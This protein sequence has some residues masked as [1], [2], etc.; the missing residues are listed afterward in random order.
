MKRR[1]GARAPCGD[2]SGT[3]RTATGTGHP[4]RVRGAYHAPGGHAR[5]M[6]VDVSAR[7]R[8]VLT[9]HGRGSGTC[10]PSTLRSGDRADPVPRAFHARRL[11][12]TAPKAVRLGCSSPTGRGLD[13]PHAGFRA[14]C[15]VPAGNRHRETGDVDV[16]LCRLLPVWCSVALVVDRRQTQGRRR[17]PSIEEPVTEG[18]LIA[19]AVDGRWDPHERFPT[20]ASGHQRTVCQMTRSPG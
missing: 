10:R 12:P 1:A 8:S 2:D 3:C 5:H 9:R 6:V 14:W 19:L 17:G 13:R 18:E 11:P 20:I 15:I 7:D 4:E 16:G